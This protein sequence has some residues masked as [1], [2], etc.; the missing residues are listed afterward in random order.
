MLFNQVPQDDEGLLDGKGRELQY[1]VDSDGNYVKSKSSGWEPKNAIFIQAWNQIKDKMY[2]A[3]KGILNGKLSPIAYFMQL[4]IMDTTLLAEY[5]GLPKRKV[6]KHLK[7]ENFL[8][9]SPDLKKLYAQAFGL[10]PEQ[11]LDVK[12]LERITPE[13]EI[14]NK[15]GIKL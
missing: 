15:I 5:V 11:L 10:T 6:R 14:Y 3:R 9:L 12:R 8:A 2:E 7:P 13:D 4:H 1:A